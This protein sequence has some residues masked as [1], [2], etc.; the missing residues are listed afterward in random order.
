MTLLSAR[1][2]ALRAYIAWGALSVMRSTDFLGSGSRTTSPIDALATYLNQ[3]P[4]EH[5]RQ[6]PLSVVAL[7]GTSFWAHGHWH[8]HIRT[9]DPIDFQSFTALH[10]L[11]HIIDYP[12][13]QKS[14]T[15]S[16][17]DWEAMADYFAT[18]TLMMPYKLANSQ[19]GRG[20]SYGS[21]R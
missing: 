12:V 16:E 11:K 13:R 8:I 17:A 14:I 5:E 10:Q 15:F 4:P 6:D 9:S 18:Q 19:R 1:E 3:A 20:N 21:S 7:P 2:R